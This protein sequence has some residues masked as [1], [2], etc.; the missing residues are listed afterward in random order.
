MS[1]PMSNSSE[2][3]PRRSKG[4]QKIE[5][6]KMTNESNLQVTFSKRRNGL[7]KKASELC[8]LC[9]A[10]VALIVFSPAE[11]A[12]SFGDP[13]VSAVIDR[14]MMIP[15]QPNNATMQILEAH[16]CA[17]VREMNTHLTQINSDL[18][19]EKMCND[20]LNKQRKDAQ[21]QFWWATPIEEMNNAEQLEQLKKALEDLKKSVLLQAQNQI[22]PQN[23][24]PPSN[25]PPQ[26]FAGGSSSNNPP[27]MFHQPPP[28][29]QM[30]P[31]PPP[32]SFFEGGSSSNNP[33]MMQPSHVSD[34]VPSM[35]MPYP[36]GFNNMGGYGPQGGFF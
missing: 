1:N 5:M 4:R 16:R 14:Y 17:N 19:I 28:Q 7:F 22:P 29:L 12:F 36:G 30:V 25:P 33:P 23:P 32:Q 24:T 21:K 27:F 34:G 6:K 15:P 35:M 18:E 11:K 20:M 8:T 10:Q 3:N 2:S 31:L 13:S 9:G 26:F